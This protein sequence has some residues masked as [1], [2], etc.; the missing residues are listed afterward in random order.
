MDKEVKTLL[1]KIISNLTLL[2]ALI[3][4]WHWL[5][6]NNK[7]VEAFFTAGMLVILVNMLLF[8]VSLGVFDAIT[9]I[10]SKLVFV[11]KKKSFVNEKYETNIIEQEKNKTNPGDFAEYKQNKA[12]DRVVYNP[13]IGVVIGAISVLISE[14]IL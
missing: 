13:L 12:I 14:L 6:E 2:V 4:L 10:F 5:A 7:L 3:L 1:V 9:H 11:F 8:V